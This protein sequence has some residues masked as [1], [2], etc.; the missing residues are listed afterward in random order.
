M[1]NTQEIKVKKGG[2]TYHIIPTE[3][4]KTNTFIFKF[5]APL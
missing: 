1:A 2:I 3:K 4:F 5:K